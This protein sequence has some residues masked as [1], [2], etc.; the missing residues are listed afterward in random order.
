MSHHLPT[1]AP[2][3][4]PVVTVCGPSDCPGTAPA[5]SGRNALILVVEDHYVN[6]DVALRTLRKLGFRAEAVTNGREAIEALRAVAYD[7]VL[8]DVRMP[9]MNGLEATRVIRDPESGVLNSQ[10]PIVAMTVDAMCGTRKQCFEA[11]MDD[12]LGLPVS[13][14]ML[15][16]TIHSWLSGPNQRTRTDGRTHQ[17]HEAAVPF[18]HAAFLG[19]QPW[20]S[21]VLSQAFCPSVYPTR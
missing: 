3:A 9:E 18:A 16:E 2:T 12:F 4:T 13:R 10:V 5:S 7:L 21:A 14:Q 8:M 11:G 6:R 17:E 15:A 20:N 1:T 19:D